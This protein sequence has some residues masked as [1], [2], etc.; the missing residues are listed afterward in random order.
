[1]RKILWIFPNKRKKYSGI[2]K[3]NFELKKLVE[4]KSKVKIVFNGKKPNYFFTFFNKFIYLPFFLFFNSYKFDCIIYPEEGFAFLSIFSFSKEN[5]II[6][7]DYRKEYSDNNKINFKENLKQLYLNFNFLFIDFF[8][9]IIVPS[10]FTK[11]LLTKYR[12]IDKGK[13]TV[14]PNI[15]NFKNTYK[16]NN[17]RL[18]FVELLSKKFIIVMCVT[19]KESRKNIKLIYEILKYS[20]DI[21]FIIVGNIEQ[22]KFHNI[23]YMKNLRENELSYIYKKSDFFLDVSLFEG[24][25]RS[26][27]EAQYH[28]LKVICFDTKSNREILNDTAT[29]MKNSITAKEVFK[30]LKKK[31]N[32]KKIIYKNAK[33]YSP[34][35]IY[36]NFYKQINEI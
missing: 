23:Y 10:Q 17:Q 24:F 29:Y 1:M 30:I 12:V 2:Y 14:I 13:I 33:T 27:I 8:K 6:I 9:K 35:I 20:K 5:K 34:K 4:K 26:L 25:G 21:K 11:N 7:H 32:N 15:I 31:I 16:I 22:K 19:S 3:Y 28:G 36:K 18:N